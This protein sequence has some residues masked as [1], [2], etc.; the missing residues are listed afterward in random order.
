MRENLHRTLSKKFVA[1]SQACF[2]PHPSLPHQTCIPPCGPCLPPRSPVRLRLCV[3]EYQEIQTKYKE[4]YRSRPAPPLPHH[5]GAL[6]RAHSTRT[7]TNA[8]CNTLVRGVG[9]RERVGRQLK[10]VK[11]DATKVR[12]TRPV[13]PASNV[14]GA[15]SGGRGAK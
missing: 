13:V 5:T 11:P 1:L 2:P 15:G 8:R 9:G 3:Q 12:P 6:L 7:R 10:V 14:A 4:K